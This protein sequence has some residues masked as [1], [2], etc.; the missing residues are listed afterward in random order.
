MKDIG[1]ILQNVILDLGIEQPIKSYQALNRWPEVVGKRIAD[2]T[3]PEKIKNGK[4]FI[5]V[6]TDSWRN[7]MVFHKKD[8]LKNL[9]ACLG[10]NVVK[11]IV[12][13]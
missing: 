10:S 1:K 3:E 5:K 4:I 9:N 2:V 12:L 6:K 11:D 8:I 13:L 7:E